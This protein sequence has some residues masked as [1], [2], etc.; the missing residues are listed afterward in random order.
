MKSAGFL[1]GF[2]FPPDVVCFCLRYP[3]CF[4]KIILEEVIMLTNKEK[5]AGRREHRLES[6]VTMRASG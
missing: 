4:R 6:H 1:R 2:I 5:S 3:A